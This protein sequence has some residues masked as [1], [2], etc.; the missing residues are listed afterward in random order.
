MWLCCRLLNL[1]VRRQDKLTNAIPCGIS[2]A[3]TF[4]FLLLVVLVLTTPPRPTYSELLKA[5]FSLKTLAFA[6]DWPTAKQ[7]FLVKAHGRRLHR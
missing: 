7:T 2:S 1:L 5:S 3:S 4:V 6:V